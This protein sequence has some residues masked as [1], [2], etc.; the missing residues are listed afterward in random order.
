MNQSHRSYIAQSVAA[1]REKAPINGSELLRIVQFNLAL[2][3]PSGS[4]HHIH[5][6]IP[7]RVTGENYMIDGKSLVDSYESDG[8]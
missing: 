7:P 3:L 6:L 2:E 1:L 5:D 8:G 4:L